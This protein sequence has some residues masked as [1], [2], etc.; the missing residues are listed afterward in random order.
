MLAVAV[1]A[2]TAGVAIAG[3][4]PAY[5]YRDKR[6]I[7]NLWVETGAC[8]GFSTASPLLLAG[9][10][11]AAYSHW[12]APDVFG[13]EAGYTQI[14]VDGTDGAHTFHIHQRYDYPRAFR[15]FVYGYATTEIVRDDGAT[16]TGTSWLGIDPLKGS[17]GAEGVWW[18]GTPM[19]GAARH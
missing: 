16:M 17:A 3:D 18:L 6:D 13:E 4:K 14:D 15:E 19:C 5:R 12:D 7:S 8:P 10:L 11:K 2:V 9:T 1:V